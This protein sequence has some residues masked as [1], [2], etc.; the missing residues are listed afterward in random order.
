MAKG[1]AEHGHLRASKSQSAGV[2]SSNT[3]HHC[4]A[5][6]LGVLRMAPGSPLADML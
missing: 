6:G 2:V 3:N 4:E 1:F 5:K